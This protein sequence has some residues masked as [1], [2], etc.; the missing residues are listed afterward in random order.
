M[1]K[2][3]ILMAVAIV[4]VL[5]SCQTAPKANISDKVDSLSYTMGIAQTQGLKE[6]LVNRMGVDTTYMDSFIKGL[7]EGVKSGDD[8]KQTAY[9]SGVQI[10]QQVANQIIPGVSREAFGNDSTKVLDK[11]NFLAGFI[12]GTTGKDLKM[13]PAEAQATAQRLMEEFHKESLLV[14]FGD[15]KA[16]GE[17]FMDSIAKVPGV[18]KTESGLCYRIITEGKGDVPAKTDKVKVNYRG[19]LIDG[20]EFDSSYKRNDPT[21]FR[22]NQVISGWTEALTMMPVGSKWELFIPQD[23]AYGDRNQGQIKPFSTLVFDVE[24]LSI[25]K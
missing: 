10:G 23:L 14:E 2:S 18:I 3:F 16:A 1:K 25:E 4:A 15:N 17:A 5:A 22:A 19:T 12:A 9:M 13:E 21:T 20:T 24:L 7:L 8:A 11:D 6:Y